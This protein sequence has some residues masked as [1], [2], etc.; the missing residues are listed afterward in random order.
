MKSDLMMKESIYENSYYLNYI[1][2][3]ARKDVQM[4]SC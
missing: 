2:K 4:F 3:G 1:I